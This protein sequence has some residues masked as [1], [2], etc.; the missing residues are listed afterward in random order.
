[1][2]L[3]GSHSLF[4]AHVALMGVAVVVIKVEGR[5]KQGDALSDPGSAGGRVANAPEVIGGQLVPKRGQKLACMN[6]YT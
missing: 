4:D 2:Y 1:M 3:T 6:T 5:R